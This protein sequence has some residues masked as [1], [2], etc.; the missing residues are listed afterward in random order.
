MEK[1]NTRQ[2]DSASKLMGKGTNK[3]YAVYLALLGITHMAG[4]LKGDSSD[5]PKRTI[6]LF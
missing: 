4:Y 1:M 3:H 6:L 2:V 5:Y